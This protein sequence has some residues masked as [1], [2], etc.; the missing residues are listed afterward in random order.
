[1]SR[2]DHIVSVEARER[3][4]DEEGGNVSIVIDQNT[5]SK[6]TAELEEK[7][8]SMDEAL[9]EAEDPKP[10]IQKIPFMLRGNDNFIKYVHREP[11]VVSIGPYQAKN[12]NLQVTKWIKLKL[13]ALFIQYGGMNRILLY[14]RII[15]K[16]AKFR[17]CYAD[18]ATECYNNAE[19]A[20]MFL[21]D[22]CAVL[23]YIICAHYQKPEDRNQGNQQTPE[24]QYEKLKELKIKMD[25]IMFVQQ[26]LFLLDNQLPYELLDLLM[27]ME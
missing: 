12:P 4:A 6:I 2:K 23:H 21:V 7:F 13:A 9:Q 1:M 3:K 26:D 5:E 18:E 11:R 8:K 14:E 24:D 22:G 20:W 16:I 25:H 15:E 10:K 19:L 27:Q 17:E